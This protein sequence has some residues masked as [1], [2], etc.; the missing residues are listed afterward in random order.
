MV[1]EVMDSGQAAC[2]HDPGSGEAVSAGMACRRMIM[3]KTPERIK[4]RF[5]WVPPD[6]RVDK[7]GLPLP[8]RPADKRRPLFWLV[9]DGD[10]LY[11]VNDTDETLARVSSAS[12]GFVTVDDDTVSIRKSAGV[13]YLNVQPG[14]AVKVDEYD[15]IYDSDTL[16]QPQI[17]IE[18]PGIGRVTFFGPVEKGG[19]RMDAVLLWDNGDIG[20]YVDCTSEE[21]T[22]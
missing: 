12:G 8:P 19:V 3:E 15:P 4:G 7:L 14:E 2:A 9:R 20:R 6:K 1:D 10:A 5:T 22:V 21:E 11:F 17:S 13:A 16:V 18:S